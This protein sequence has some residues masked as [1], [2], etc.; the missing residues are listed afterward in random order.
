MSVGRLQDVLATLQ[1]Q[2]TAGINAS[3]VPGMTVTPVNV[4]A[5]FTVAS[6]QVIIGAPLAPEFVSI[7]GSS[8]GQWQ[9]SVFPMK[10]RSVTR[11]RPNDQPVFLPG[12]AT[13][14]A[15]QSGDTVTFSG[16]V[17][18]LTN[19]HVVIGTVADAYVQAAIGQS[20]TSIAAAV[21]AA[22]NALGRADI[23]AV[24]SGAAVTISAPYAFV[25]NLGVSGTLY[26][27]V[28]RAARTVQ[29][30]TWASD[31]DTRSLISSAI[32]SSV[33]GVSNAWLTLP[34]T[35][36]MLALY[37]GDSF[38]DINQSSYSM[39]LATAYFAVEYGIFAPSAATPIGAVV[40]TVQQSTALVT[41][42][43]G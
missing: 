33:G 36:R 20:L 24:A 27:E 13:L 35:T 7:L 17:S 1:A 16:S 12:P 9:V 39:Y 15:T 32:L 42:Y 37:D 28:A 18:S 10:A 2:V 19:I 14:V 40:S 4:E 23:A 21:A 41:T 34:D 8:P 43:S 30:V 25:C 26:Q 11:Y 3:G 22:V 38:D 6:G 5:S 29:V 31:P